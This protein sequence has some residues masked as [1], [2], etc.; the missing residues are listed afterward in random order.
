M[1]IFRG[2]RDLGR[3]VADAFEVG[4]D[5]DRRH[6]GAQIVGGRLAPHDQVAAGVVER[7]F[8]LVD[9]VILGDHAVGAV[10]VADAE[11]RHRVE[12][13]GLDDAAHQQDL[14]A[15]GLEFVVVLLG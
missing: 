1:Q 12:E 4:D 11:T 5:L 15:D 6:H 14:G 9:G 2:A 7:H 3:L 13:L 10:L 8:E